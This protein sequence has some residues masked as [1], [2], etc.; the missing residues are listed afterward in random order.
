MMTVSEFIWSK[1]FLEYQIAVRRYRRVFGCNLRL[2]LCDFYR[3]KNSSQL[4]LV[5]FT[6]L[7]QN[8]VHFAFSLALVKFALRRCEHRTIVVG[9]FYWVGSC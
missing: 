5:S 3:P 2:F 7:L 8:S 6:H 9:F 4:Q 1:K